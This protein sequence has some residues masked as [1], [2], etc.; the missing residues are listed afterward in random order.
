MGQAGPPC[1]VPAAGMCQEHFAG[2]GQS[3]TAHS[4]NVLSCSFCRGMILESQ[5][6]LFVFS[7]RIYTLF[8]SSCC[9]TF[10][11]VRPPPFLWKNT[12]YFQS[13]VAENVNTHRR[14]S[15]ACCFLC[16]AL[17][18]SPASLPAFPGQ[19]LTLGA[20]NITNAST[21]WNSRRLHLHRAR[22]L[23]AQECEML[24]SLSSIQEPSIF[25]FRNLILPFSGALCLFSTW[26]C[27]L[28][29]GELCLVGC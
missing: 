16:R 11:I 24:P 20:L 28:F 22:C 25:H 10:L 9:L 19:V 26:C 21:P 5:L 6:D 18:Y 15:S 23:G 12:R 17:L 4:G 13:D 8:D 3:G 14:W 1:M 2:R 29:H 7:E 27:T